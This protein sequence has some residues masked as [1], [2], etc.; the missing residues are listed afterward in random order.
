VHLSD[1]LALFPLL[2]VRDAGT[3]IA[4]RRAQP[5]AGASMTPIVLLHGIGSASASWLRQLQHCGRL[6]T[7]L[8]WNAPG[9]SESSALPMA[10]PCANDYARSM[11]LWLDALGVGQVTLVG[12][13]L[14][15]LMAAA[16]TR[17]A[18]ERVRQLLLLAPALGYA[19]ATPEV[20]ATKLNDR[21]RN[22]ETLGPQ[23]IADKRGAAMLSGNAAPEQVEFI[24]TVMAQIE[25]HGYAQAAHML[26]GGNLAADL[27]AITCPIT[28]ASG[29]AD[30]IT[31][32]AGCQLAAK[33]ARTPWIDLG[34]VGHACPLEAAETVNRMIES[35]AH[36]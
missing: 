35:A 17:S 36:A 28:V 12:H 10:L 15:A 24:K 9:Y 20:R 26:S 30:T 29:H 14:G 25:P 32:P 27:A 4:Y 23:G 13:S 31:P 1:Q 16:A 7:V 11:W 22:L 8:A 3:Q 34:A 21:L 6:R 33:A 2:H 5:A 18:P 19:A